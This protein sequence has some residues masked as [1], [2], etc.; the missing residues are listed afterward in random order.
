M[1]Q[2][3]EELTGLVETVLNENKKL[4]KELSE[5]SKGLKA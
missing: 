1:Y 4:K 5:T 2:K 3:L